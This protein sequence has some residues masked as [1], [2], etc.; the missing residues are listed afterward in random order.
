MSAAINSRRG[1]AYALAAHLIWGAMAPYLGLIRYIN[2]LEIAVH[3]GLWSVPLAGLVVWRLGLE[4][5]VIRVLKNYRLMALLALTSSIIFVNWAGYI[6]CIQNGRALE[7]SLGYFINP[8]LNVA[9]GYLFLRERFTTA[10]FVA[11]GVAVFAVLLLTV[12]T[13]VFPIYGILLA[14]SFCTYGLLRKI[15]P[16]SPVTGFFYEVAIMALPLLLLET[17]L[18]KNGAMQFGNGTFNTAMLIGSAGFTTGALIFYALG[19]KALRYS[20]AG[21]IQYLTPS[22]IFLTAVFNFG[23]PVGFWK[24]V[25]FVL[26]WLALAIYS[27]AAVREERQLRAV[28]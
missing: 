7:A 18:A 19:V 12:S 4:P 13:G 26:I 9:A 15:M 22:L 16:V 10:Q 11:I 27:V 5:E 8:L 25:S 1:V 21:L 20:T 2:P 23:E 17:W 24:L 14:V 6:W 28:A 3:R